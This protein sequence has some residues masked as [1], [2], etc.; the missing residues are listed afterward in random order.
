MCDYLLFKLKPL[1]IVAYFGSF[2]EALATRKMLDDKYEKG[3]YLVMSKREA[4]QQFPELTQEV[5]HV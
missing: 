5:K 1:Q 4:L 2:H 3:T